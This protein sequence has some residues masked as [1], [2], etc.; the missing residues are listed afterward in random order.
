[1]KTLIDK[2]IISAIV[3]GIALSIYG[4]VTLKWNAYHQRF[5]NASFWTFLID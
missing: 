2:L 4:I 5:P 3:T 1:M